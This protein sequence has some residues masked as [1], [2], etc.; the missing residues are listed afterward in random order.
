MRPAFDDLSF[1]EHQN[2]IGVLHGGK[3]VRDHQNRLFLRQLFKGELNLM[4]VLSARKSGCFIQNDDR[5]VFQNGA[6]QR[7]ALI[8]AAGEVS[9]AVSYNGVKPLREASDDFPALGGLG[10]AQNLLPR[11]VRPCGANVFQHRILEQPGILEH[12]GD[13]IHQRLL[14]DLPYIHAAHQNAPFRSVVKARNQLRSRGFAAAGRAHQ[15]DGLSGRNLEG[16]MIQRFFTGTGMAE[17]YVF[18]GHGS[19]PGLLRMFRFRQRLFFQNAFNAG[20]RALGR[21][22]LLAGKHDAAHH[23]GADRRKQAVK[24]EGQQHILISGLTGQAGKNHAGHGNQQN[25]GSVQRYVK[26]HQGNAAFQ[27]IIGGVLFIFLDRR[28]EVLEGINRLLEHLYY[29]NAADVFYRFLVHGFQRGHV[30]F[31]K[32]GVVA[33][34][35]LLQEEKADN[36]RNQTAQPQPPVKGKDQHKHGARQIRQ[37]MRQKLL[38]EPRIVVDR[39]NPRRRCE[40]TFS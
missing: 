40:N 9:A 12:K 4:F 15:R 36:H 3:T 23:R 2:F 22:Q 28:V 31:H 19:V 14:S 6:R 25:K 35:H 1:V 18:K 26:A 7:D 37:L 8:F 16:D 27:R 32:V 29:G 20:D 38:R 33:A 10:G 5:R 30:A 39:R 11:G 17:G 21:H 13:L 24:Q 34:H